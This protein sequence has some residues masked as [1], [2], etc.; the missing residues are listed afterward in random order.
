[1][2]IILLEFYSKYFYELFNHRG[3]IWKIIRFSKNTNK[4]YTTLQALD[5]LRLITISNFEWIR[6]T[7]HPP[8]A[9]L[10]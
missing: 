9:T 6:P 1:M 5:S 4:L 8:A 10:Q 3:C 7:V 2:L